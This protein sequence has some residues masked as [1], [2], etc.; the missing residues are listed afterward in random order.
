MLCC[1]HCYT[2]CEQLL[3]LT[4][5]F[6][7]RFAT[8]VFFSVKTNAVLFFCLLLLH[9]NSFFSSS[10]D[11]G[12]HECLQN[13]LF[14]LDK[15]DFKITYLVSMHNNSFYVWIKPR[16]KTPHFIKSRNIFRLCRMF[17]VFTKYIAGSMHTFNFFELTNL[18]C[19][20]VLLASWSCTILIPLLCVCVGLCRHDIRL[21]KLIHRFWSSSIS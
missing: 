3:Q 15:K 14:C 2:H 21:Y 6:G 4:E 10:Q 7:F 8:C 20:L 5:S 11:T 16:C 13:D 1:V 19:Q 18:I 9:Y 17:T 12:W